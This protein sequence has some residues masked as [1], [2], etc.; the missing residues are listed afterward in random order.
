MGTNN[1]RTLAFVFISLFV[2]SVLATALS[3]LIGVL[4]PEGVVQ[5]FFF[6]E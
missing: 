2:G 5:D 6:N 4:L 3:D 1:K